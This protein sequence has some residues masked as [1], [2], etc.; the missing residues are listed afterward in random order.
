MRGSTPG[1]LS[2]DDGFLELAGI[3]G[4]PDNTACGHRGRSD[5]DRGIGE[6]TQSR[7]VGLPQVSLSIKLHMQAPQTKDWQ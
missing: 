7:E 5:H 4:G 6:Y 2:Q 3:R 1:R